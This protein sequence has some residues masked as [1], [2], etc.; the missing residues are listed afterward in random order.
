MAW[1]EETSNHTGWMVVDQGRNDDIVVSNH[2]TKKNA[3]KAL[4]KYEHVLK[5]L[6]NDLEEA[7]E[8]L[9]GNDDFI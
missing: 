3:L 9:I 6:G 4:K 1:I 8:G 7:G 5:N 2:K